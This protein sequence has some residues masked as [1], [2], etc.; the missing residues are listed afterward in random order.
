MK[1]K[2]SF[3]FKRHIF[4]HHY[5]EIICLN[6]IPESI[7]EYIETH[8]IRDRSEIKSSLPYQTQ[9]T[10]EA[11]DFGKFGKNYDKSLLFWAL[12]MSLLY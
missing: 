8:K 10:E 6:K 1:Q 4:L 12:F 11:I 9:D 2:K 3:N 7:I 5:N